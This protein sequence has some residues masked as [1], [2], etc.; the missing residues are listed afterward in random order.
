MAEL[1]AKRKAFEMKGALSCGN[2]VRAKTKKVRLQMSRQMISPPV[3]RV[4]DPISSDLAGENE[5]ARRDAQSAVHEILWTSEDALSDW[6]IFQEYHRRE[7]G[8]LT[9]QRLRTARKELQNQGFVE[10]AGFQYGAS[11]TGRKAMTWA[12]C[13]RI[14]DEAVAA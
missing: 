1:A 8:M 14:A 9:Q 7:M 12:W 4:T 10:P 13:S 3:A 2:S 6:Q 11:E 5:S